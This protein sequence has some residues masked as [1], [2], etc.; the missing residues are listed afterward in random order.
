MTLLIALVCVV[1]VAVWLAPMIPHP[2]GQILR[3]V[4]WI[5]AIVLV[6]YLAVGLLTGVTAGV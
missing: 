3:V 4:C 2:G 6:I 5:V 1:L